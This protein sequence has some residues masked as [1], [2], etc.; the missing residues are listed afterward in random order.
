MTPRRVGRHISG[1]PEPEDE[2][3]RRERD[4]AVRE[5]LSHWA[6]GVT[7]VAVRAGSRVHA[8]TVSAFMPVSVDPPLVLVGLGPN[9]AVLPFL[10]PDT[11]FTVNLLAADQ[12]GLASRYA[13]S[14]PV[15]DSPFPGDGDPVVDGA[16]ACLVCE[17][18]ELFE[19]GD[20][21]LALG[22]VVDARSG[23]PD[24]ALAYY[25]RQYH[26]LS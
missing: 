7:L 22:R 1:G 12:K 4:E 24:A 14:F 13:D 11:R 15:G 6:S 18:Q 3:R 8:L 2:R 17:V 26:R 25:R 19:R 5:A 23:G 10:D 9:A 21:A 20:H 16:L